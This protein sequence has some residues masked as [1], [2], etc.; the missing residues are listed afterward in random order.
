MIHLRFFLYSLATAFYSLLKTV[1]VS[2]AQ[3]LLHISP[4]WHYSI[5][6]PT[7]GRV[8]RRTQANDTKIHA[9]VHFL[10]CY[11]SLTL[12]EHI[13]VEQMQVEPK[14]FNMLANWQ[15]EYTMESILTQ[16]KKEM[17]APHNRK[18]VQPPEGT[19]FQNNGPNLIMLRLP[20][21]VTLLN[22]NLKAS[23]T[24]ACMISQLLCF[25]YL[26]KW[27]YKMFELQSCSLRHYLLFFVQLLCAETFRL[28]GM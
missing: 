12:F 20:T 8:K 15:R 5:P 26:R 28:C 22:C 1:A 23:G 27:K 14:K 18:L 10:D 9:F 6:W 2:N 7:S 11:G 13:L 21:T 19:F 4:V 16:L 24:K 3:L 17:A 25:L